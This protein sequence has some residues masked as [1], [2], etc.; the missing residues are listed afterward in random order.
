M[1]N[2]KLNS[3]YALASAMV[4]GAAACSAGGGDATLSPTSPRFH[5]ETVQVLRTA[6]VCKVGPVGTYDFSASATG[7]DNAGDS[8]VSNFSIPVTVA[9]SPTCV[10]VFTRINAEPDNTGADAPAAVTVTELAHAGTTLQNLTAT[11]GA[12]PSVINGA[13][14]T[15]YINGFHDATATYTNV[16]DHVPPP[17]GGCTYTQGWYKNHTSK[18]PTGFAPS[19]SFDGWLSWINLYNTPPKGSQ[20]IILAHQYMTALMNVA[21]GASVPPAVQTALDAAAAYFAAGGNGAGSGNIAGVAGVLD[22]YNNGL[23]AG[24][25]AHCSDEVIVH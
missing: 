9:G 25:P 24:G 7:N 20:Y 23:A 19:T 12:T 22:A 16:A 17:T 5:E 15:M 13:T 11:D 3:C 18:W 6:Q 2:R 4:L 10:T 21:S 8:Q 14:V 1:N